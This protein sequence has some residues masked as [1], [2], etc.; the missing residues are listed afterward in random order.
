[1]KTKRRQGKY[2]NDNKRAFEEIFRKKKFFIV[3][4]FDVIIKYEIL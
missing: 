3:F 2:L 4:I 1:M